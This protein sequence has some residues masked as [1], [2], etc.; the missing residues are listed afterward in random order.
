V[1]L[2][3]AVIFSLVAISLAR[4][5]RLIRQL[6]YHRDA[7][8]PSGSAASG[9][10]LPHR[11]AV[12]ALGGAVLLNP[13]P[14]GDL[15][16]TSAI[17][18]VEPRA[19]I[20]SLEIADATFSYLCEHGLAHVACLARVS[21][22]ALL[23]SFAMVCI[24]LPKIFF[25]FSINSNLGWHMIL[26]STIDQSLVTLGLGLCA[27]AGLYAV[28]AL[29]QRTLEIRRTRWRY[30]RFRLMADLTSEVQS[31][32]K[33]EALAALPEPGPSGPPPASPLP[34]PTEQPPAT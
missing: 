4:S 14:N 3:L 10:I 15:A 25:G 23:L 33:C 28:A 13:R 7:P 12:A 29:L 20:R 21:L 8:D 9:A 6:W 34:S 2:F 5:V 19:A 1:K 22:L 31:P 11:L 30:F 24:G 27:A 32:G 18:T 17:S 26:Y 16:P